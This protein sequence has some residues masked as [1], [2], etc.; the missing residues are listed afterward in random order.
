[1]QLM[2]SSTPGIT[3]FPEEGNLLKWTATIAGPEETYYRSS[4]HLRTYV[5]S[6]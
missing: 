2:M 1:M 3:A 4:G 5:I 6:P